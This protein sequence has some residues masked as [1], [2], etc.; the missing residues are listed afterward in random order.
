MRK[1]QVRQILMSMTLMSLAVF[2]NLRMKKTTVRGKTRRRAPRFK[3][4]Y[5]D[6]DLRFP[7]FSLGLEFPTM[8]ECIEAIQYYAN[9]CVRLLKFVKNE[10]GRL[11]VKCNGKAEKRHCPWV[12]YA[13]HVGK[14]L[15]VRVKTI[16]G[17]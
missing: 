13:S 5:R 7:K 11:R 8:I 1:N 4:Y 2:M 10:P 17:E 16:L 14:S 3:Q 15:T 9:S 6:H 12:L